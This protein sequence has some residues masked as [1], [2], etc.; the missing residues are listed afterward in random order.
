MREPDVTGVYGRAWKSGAKPQNASQTAALEAWIVQCPMAHP[1]WHTY[2][3]YVV[4]LR[5]IPGEPLP[6]LQYPEAEYEFGLVALH[7]DHEVDPDDADTI[8]HLTPPNVIVQ[9]H[10]CSDE[11]AGSIADKA[12]RIIVAGGM[13]PEPE[14]VMGAREAWQQSIRATAAHENDP[15]HGGTTCGPDGG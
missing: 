6:N 11:W 15:T 14:G 12:A 3:L 2:A 7:P 1:L 8:H 5:A 9:F 4:H 10:G 13:T